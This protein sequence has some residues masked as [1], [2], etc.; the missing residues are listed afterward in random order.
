MND[1]G[2]SVLEQYDLQIFTTRRGRGALICET[3]QGN[4]LL[5]EFQGS[6]F[7]LGYQQKMLKSLE[8]EGFPVDTLV[9]NKE[10]ELISLDRDETPYIVKKWFEGR[11]CDTK[12]EQDIL[13]AVKK[14]AALHKYMKFEDFETLNLEERNRLCAENLILEYDR[15]NKELKKVRNFIRSKRRKSQ[16][17]LCYL[18]HYQEFYEQGEEILDQIKT[19]GYEKLWENALN[20]GKVCHGEFNHH[21]LVYCREGVIV[22]NFDKCCVDLQIS[23]LYHFMRKI[24]EKHDWDASLGSKMVDQYVKVRSTDK[25]ELQNLRLRLSYPEKFWKVANHYYNGNK[26]WIPDKN[27]EKLE[28]LVRQNVERE[29]FLQELFS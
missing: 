6:R 15:H 25:S 14:L 21:N 4:K 12:S 8:A 27:T 16:F 2:L 3:D 11:E 13:A 23:D 26:A 5:K 28:I 9:E 19:S 7:K 24:L 10:G 22:T 17:E 1:R 29:R 18:N 20:E